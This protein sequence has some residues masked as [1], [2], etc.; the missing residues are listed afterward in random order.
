MA[1]TTTPDITA[2]PST[3]ATL[4][5]MVTPGTTATPDIM[6]IPGTTGINGT[7]VIMVAMCIT[8]AGIAMAVTM[9][10]AV[11]GIIAKSSSCCATHRHGSRSDGDAKAP[12]G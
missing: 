8:T 4:A 12:C 7:L 2:T 9:V 5:I 3:T 11:V 10:K 6:V 1:C